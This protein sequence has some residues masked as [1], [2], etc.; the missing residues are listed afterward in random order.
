MRRVT[1]FKGYKFIIEFNPQTGEFETVKAPEE[2]QE[3][4]LD[5]V[6]IELDRVLPFPVSEEKPKQS[7]MAG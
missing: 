3:P 5:E 4:T 1:E 6:L 2:G 7:R